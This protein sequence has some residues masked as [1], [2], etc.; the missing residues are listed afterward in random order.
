LPF[1][2]NYTAAALKHYAD[3]A[4]LHELERHDNAAYLGGY[5]VEC[6]LKHVLQLHGFAAA[7]LGHELRELGGRALILAAILSPSANRYRFHR[8]D[9]VHSSVQFW[10]PE[11]RYC[12]EGIVSRETSDEVLK[13]AA[14]CV[15][16]L[17]LPAILDGRARM[18]L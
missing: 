16:E 13:A 6:S 11:I 18:P 1:V 15:E 2:E 17:V 10:T 7:A 3:A 4:K 14:T 8:L 5:V 12:A 9:E